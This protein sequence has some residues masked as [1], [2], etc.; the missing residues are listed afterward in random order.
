M[1]TQRSSRAHEALLITARSTATLR[2][3]RFARSLVRVNADVRR[4]ALNDPREDCDE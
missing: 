4:Q 1:H 3:R 2:K